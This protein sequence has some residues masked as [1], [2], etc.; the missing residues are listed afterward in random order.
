MSFRNPSNIARYEYVKYSTQ[1]NIEEPAADRTQHKQQFK[2]I[3]DGT[4]NTDPSDYYNAKLMI[5]FKVFKK[6]DGAYFA[7]ADKI[8]V[9]GD[10][11]SFIN[12]LLVKYNNSMVSDTP[13]INRAITVKNVAEYPFS[14]AHGQ[15][16]ESFFYPSA[17]NT[18]NDDSLRIKQNLIVGGKTNTIYLPLN[19]YDW[20]RSFKTELCPP[21][22]LELDITVEED[23]IILQRA[24]DANGGAGDGK[25]IIENM[26][27]HIPMFD[28]N[29][30]GMALY[31][32]K[33]LT[34]HTWQYLKDL[35]SISDVQTHQSGKYMISPGITAP[36]HVFVWFKNETGGDAQLINQFIFNT[37][38]VGTAP[39]SLVSCQL[40]ASNGVFYPLH[41][42]RPEEYPIEVYNAFNTFASS[43]RWGSSFVS[44]TNFINQYGI[45]YFNLTHQDTKI[46]GG[47]PSI[48]FS[49]NLSR[50]PGGPGFRIQ[51]LVMYEQNLSVEVASGK[52]MLIV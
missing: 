27:L 16:S 38:S 15:A 6:V 32:E 25:L 8:Y 22:R 50:A 28:F 44:Y 2:F 4:T 26:E 35:V 7:A 20:F 10:G 5:K 33:F 9:S 48:E 21:G 39:A 41:P 46:R 19:R 17:G 36:K 14:F 37:F 30:V 51:S 40:T 29:P 18:D 23:D 47:S 42:Y 34:N 43:G 49:Y 13:D 11:Y 52:T 31:S 12:R 24:T 1:K 45:I 3:A